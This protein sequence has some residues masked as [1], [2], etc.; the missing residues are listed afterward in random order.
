MDINEIMKII[1]HRFPFLYIDKILE[2]DLAKGTIVAQKN[3]TMNEHY[4]QGHF[5]NNPIM[6]GVIILEALAQT[7]GVMVHLK[8]EMPRIA[9]LLNVNNAKFRKPV[10]PGDILILKCEGLHFS[11]KGGRVKAEAFVDDKIAV[12][13]EIGFALV[14]QSQI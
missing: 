2:M 11:S 10:Y 12:Q 8:A 9:V 7:G 4:F 3:V 13:A 1:P 5:P 14:D 6:P